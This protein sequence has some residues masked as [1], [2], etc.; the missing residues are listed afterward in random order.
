VAAAVWGALVF[1]ETLRSNDEGSLKKRAFAA[2]RRLL[3]RM[4]TLAASTAGAAAAVVLLAMLAAGYGEVEFASN[5]DED[6]LVFLSDPGRAPERLVSVPAKKRATVR[7]PAG[8][9]RVYFAPATGNGE[10][11]STAR[12][13]VRTN[14]RGGEPKTVTVPEVPKYVRN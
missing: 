14:L 5:A 13:E 10:P 7:V 4:P 9:R 2:Y 6:V 11:Y 3:N 12:F 8:D 1:V